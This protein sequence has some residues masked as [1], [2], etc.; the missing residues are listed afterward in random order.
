LGRAA[1][2][3][4][5]VNQQTKEIVLRSAVFLLL[6]RA[7]LDEAGAPPKFIFATDAIFLTTKGTKIRRGQTW[8][9]AQSCFG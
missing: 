1:S 8:F 3:K 9:V 6:I 5:I 7:G 2:F 4:Q